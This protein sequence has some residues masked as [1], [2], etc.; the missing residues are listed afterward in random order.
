MLWN[1][2]IWN[3]AELPAWQRP[4]FLYLLLEGPV[5]LSF[6]CSGR[7]SHSLEQKQCAK[8]RSRQ[9][10]SELASVTGV[11]GSQFKQELI[12]SFLLG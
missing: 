8:S 9:I 3:T 1:S 7:F 4:V 6:F 2:F 12:S 5:S 10:M 11:I